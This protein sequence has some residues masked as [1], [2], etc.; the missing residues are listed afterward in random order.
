MDAYGKNII[1]FKK[2]E[3][4]IPQLVQLRVKTLEEHPAEQDHSTCA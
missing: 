2:K 3:K 4:F 1:H